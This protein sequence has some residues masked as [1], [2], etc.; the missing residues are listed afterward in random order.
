MNQAKKEEEK[1]KRLLAH[2]FSRRLQILKKAQEFSQADKIANAVGYYH[3]YLKIIAE[4]HGVK[5]EK[6][7]P[8]HFD[9]KKELA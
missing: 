2:R 5:E 4:Y 9:T 6:I 3:E 8:T 7:R 1:E